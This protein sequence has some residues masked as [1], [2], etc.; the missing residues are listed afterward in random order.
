ML[1]NIV[2]REFLKGRKFWKNFYWGK[3]LNIGSKYMYA[4]NYS[5]TVYFVLQWLLL[6]LVLVKCASVYKRFGWGCRDHTLPSPLPNL[7]VFWA[8]HST[9]KWSDKD[10]QLWLT[11]PSLQTWICSLVNSS[12]LLLILSGTVLL[13]PAGS[14]AWR[15]TKQNLFKLQLK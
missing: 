2:N 6:D 12:R 1:F 11:S 13:S 3:I 7:P 9:V 10:S 14:F 5:L 15:E 8:H 4:L